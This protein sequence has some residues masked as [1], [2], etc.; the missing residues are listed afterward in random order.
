MPRTAHRP[1]QLRRGPFRGRD[2][3]ASGLLSRGQLGAPVW[4]HLGRG[5]YADV[6]LELT[7]LLRIRAAVLWLPPNAVITGRS[8]AQLW[9]VELAD[10]DDVI[11]ARPFA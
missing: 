3:V 5:V 8:A 6:D 4:R 11:D 2:A 9:G 7:P 10:P 1:S